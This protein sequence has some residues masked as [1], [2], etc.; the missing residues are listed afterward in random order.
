MNMRWLIVSISIALTGCSSGDDPAVVV[1]GGPQL[2]VP[3]GDVLEASVSIEPALD[4]EVSASQL[5]V[6]STAELQSHFAELT[7]VAGAGG[8][9]LLRAVPYCDVLV[10]GSALFEVEVRANV[11]ATVKPAKLAVQVTAQPDGPC[12]PRL[13]LWEDTGDDCA[14]VGTAIGDGDRGVSVVPGVARKLCARVESLDPDNEPLW[15]RLSTNAP[16][17]LVAPMPKADNTADAR[18]VIDLLANPHVVGRFEIQLDVYRQDPDN[19]DT[20]IDPTITERTSLLVGE[21]G[22]W[23]IE[24]LATDTSLVVDEFNVAAIPVRVWHYSERPQEAACIRASR[25]PAVGSSFDRSKPFLRLYGASGGVVDPGEALCDTGTFTLRVSPPIDSEPVEGVRIEVG[26]EATSFTPEF[27]RDIS[28]N[29][30]SRAEE[31]GC[32]DTDAPNPPPPVVV[33]ADLDTTDPTPEVL[34][35]TA[36][37]NRRSCVF[38]GSGGRFGASPLTWV[39]AQTPPVGVISFAWDNGTAVRNV[40]MAQFGVGAGRQL[41]ELMVNAGAGTVEWASAPGLIALPDSVELAHASPVAQQVGGAATHMAFAQARAGAWSIRIDCISAACASYEITDVAPLAVDRARVGLADLDGDGNTDVVFLGERDDGAGRRFLVVVAVSP[42][43]SSPSAACGS[44]ATCVSFAEQPITGTVGPSASVPAPG[45]SF[46]QL[47]AIT[48]DTGFDA[49]LLQVAGSNGYFT[50][51]PGVPGVPLVTPGPALG[52]TATDD[53]LVASLASGV[54]SFDNSGLPASWKLVD[55]V[56]QEDAAA[57]VIP[58]TP[59][60][61]GRGLSACLV[62]AGQPAA[63]AFSSSNTSVR[64]TELDVVVAEP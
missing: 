20:T 57:G 37:D 50:S 3:E 18:L 33:C 22:S 17:S 4:E 16:E 32:S 27:T 29:V 26:P 30:T 5:E 42:D 14:T 49:S 64:Y 10:S 35:R 28:I 8:L 34:I 59:I 61:Y 44:T 36:S 31:L 52:V 9:P 23:A 45:Q 2:T 43:W 38:A 47:Y 15:A 41:S 63:F 11:G 1:A 25:F 55:P 7:V 24:V 12:L 19:G 53:T 40:V 56:L 46:H 13:T 62:A 58:V 39:G 51:P 48:G 54:W 60:G 21:R 6:V